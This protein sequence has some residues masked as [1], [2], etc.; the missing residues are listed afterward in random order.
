MEFDQHILSTSIGG[1]NYNLL[2]EGVHLYSVL[3][4]DLV[5]GYPLL[6]N[7]VHPVKMTLNCR[8]R[9]YSCTI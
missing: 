3:A 7:K 8:P 4:I 2:G 9:L 1:S 6:Y 5:L